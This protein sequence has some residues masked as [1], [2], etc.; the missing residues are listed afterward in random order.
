MDLLTE[1][2]Y[3]LKFRFFVSFEESTKTMSGLLII[4]SLI[5]VFHM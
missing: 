4:I 2:S 3:S 1:T 5:L